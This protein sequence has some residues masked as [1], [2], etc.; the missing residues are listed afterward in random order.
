MRFSLSVAQSLSG[1][2]AR[3]TAYMICPKT[4]IFKNIFFHKLLII[5]NLRFWHKIGN[6]N[7]TKQ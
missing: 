2:I 7:K 3:P 1:K 4:D 5:S 6:K